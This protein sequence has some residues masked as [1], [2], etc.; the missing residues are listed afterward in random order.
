MEVFLAPLS[1][2][3]GKTTL[4]KHISNRK[5]DIPPNID[6]LYC[7]QGKGDNVIAI[8][9]F[10][11]SEIEVDDTPAVEAVVKSDKKRTS[12]LEEE[13]ALTVK[14]ETGDMEANDRL[15]EV[16]SVSRITSR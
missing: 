15:K 9:P 16:G 10:L 2:R 4:L 12:L 14:V 7:E 1:Y 13:T 8:I 3:M 6:I 11:F 5:L